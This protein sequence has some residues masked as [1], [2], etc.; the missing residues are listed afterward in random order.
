MAFTDAGIYYPTNSDNVSLVDSFQ[1]FAE[2]VSDKLNVVQVAYGQTS[3]QV[4]NSSVTDFLSSGLTVNIKPKFSTSNVLI[5]V[6]LPFSAETQTG[7]P[8]GNSYVRATFRL[9]RGSTILVEQNSGIGG[10]GYYQVA[11]AVKFR[12]S[13]NMSFFDS[14]ATT[15]TVTYSVSGLISADISWTHKLLRMNFVDTGA[16]LSNIVA[17]EVLA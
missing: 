3:T 12:D 8:F 1:L 14:P 7:S 6:T 17:M 16:G 2:S 13:L 11:N 4:T 15:S 10:I 9:L 5:F